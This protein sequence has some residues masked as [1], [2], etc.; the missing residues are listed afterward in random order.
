MAEENDNDKKAIVLLIAHSCNWYR[1]PIMSMWIVRLHA[2]PYKGQVKYKKDMERM[3]RGN[4][5][6]IRVTEEHDNVMDKNAIVF[7][8]YVDGQWCGYC[9]EVWSCCSR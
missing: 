3:R 9:K 6:M 7:E 4:L 1:K 2:Q 8:V 5:I